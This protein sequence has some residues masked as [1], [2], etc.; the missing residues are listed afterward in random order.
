MENN[1]YFQKKQMEKSSEN[2]KD[3]SNENKNGNLQEQSYEESTILNENE[4][5]AFNEL[6]EMTECLK[7]QIK[8]ETTITK[9]YDD[10]A[11]RLKKDEEEN[12]K[13]TTIEQ[14]PNYIYE[15]IKAKKMLKSG[16]KVKQ[17]KTK[18]HSHK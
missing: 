9:D 12:S 15:V 3:K 8:T 13:E 1:N 2:P 5:I 7:Y 4:Q 17:P 11:D 10:Y 14:I 6:S 16:K 18:K